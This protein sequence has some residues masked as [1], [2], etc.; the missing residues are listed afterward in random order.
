MQ[1]E[2]AF[3]YQLNADIYVLIAT[4]SL[5][6]LSILKTA[7]YLYI[8]KWRILYISGLVVLSLG[9][10]ASIVGFVHHLVFEVACSWQPILRYISA[11]L[12]SFFPQSLILGCVGGTIFA[13]HSHSRLFLLLSGTFVLVAKAICIGIA[14]RGLDPALVIRQGLCLGIFV[15]RSF[16]GLPLADIAINV[17]AVIGTVLAWLKLKRAVPMATGMIRNPAMT[18]RLLSWILVAVFASTLIIILDLLSFGTRGGEDAYL[19]IPYQGYS[20][21]FSVVVY[22]LVSAAEFETHTTPINTDQHGE[23]SCFSIPSTKNYSKSHRLDNANGTNSSN[24]FPCHECISRGSHQSDIPLD[25]TRLMRDEE[26][27]HRV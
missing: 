1:L 11:M 6:T 3:M 22:D 10:V 17:L 21:L 20:T 4:I 27:P 5:F 15:H 2:A 19:V 9:I 24:D 25:Y 8:D 23:S 14:L 16:I 26:I 13:S 12:L 7:Y 18:R